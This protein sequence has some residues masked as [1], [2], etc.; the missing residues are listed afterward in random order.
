MLKVN[1]LKYIHRLIDD[2]ECLSEAP[3][4]VYDKHN[5]EPL[6]EIINELIKKLK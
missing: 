5:I 2:I 3:Q 4:G 1:K 6:D